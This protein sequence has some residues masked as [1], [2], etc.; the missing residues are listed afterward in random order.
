MRKIKSFKSILEKKKSFIRTTEVPIDEEFTLPLRGLSAY[1]KAL[2]IDIGKVKPP[3]KTRKMT[4]EEQEAF[5]KENPNIS[6][7]MIKQYVVAYY[8]ETDPQYLE[9]KKKN[10][11]IR[12]LVE[13]AKFVDLNYPV[14][15]DVALWQDLGLKS[16]DD[17]VGLT[18][19]LFV[20]M[21]LG[22]DF[23]KKMAQGINSLEGDILLTKL[24]K[25]ENFYKDKSMFDIMD[26]LSAEAEKAN[27][28]E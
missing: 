14:T 13:Y 24:A 6:E 22:E 20:D 28:G 7:V 19:L 18:N 17:V 1:K 27:K 23:L 21:E 26:M 12:A 10:D 8:D 16:A 3:T 15:K 25:L 5:A 11:I 9:D 2:S 4:K